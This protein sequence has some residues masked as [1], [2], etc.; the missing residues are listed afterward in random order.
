M[1]ISNGRGR[2]RNW[3]TIGYQESLVSDWKNILSELAVPCFVS[4]LHDKDINSENNIKK[5]HYHILFMFDGV[6]SIEQAKELTDIIGSVGQEN[7]MSTR[8]YARY[9]C[10]LDN[11]DKAQYSVEDVLSFGGANYMDMIASQTDKY[12]II[13]EMMSFCDKYNVNS[14][15]AL[16]NYARKHREDW[17]KV[18]IDNGAYIMREWL[19][20]RLWSISNGCAE[21]VD[22]DTGEILS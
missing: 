15:Y 19:T 14:L 21:I 9:L 17:R 13:D 20:S 18:L 11:P 22:P 3:A 1:A 7:V 16:M 8:G 2:T 12:A 10:H 5:P 4:P 6:K